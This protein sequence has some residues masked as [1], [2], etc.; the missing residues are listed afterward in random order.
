MA[1]SGPDGGAGKPDAG[2]TAQ[3]DSTSDCRLVDDRCCA[4][5]PPGLD[6]P[7]RAVSIHAREVE[8]PCEASC[9]ACPENDSTPVSLLADC[10]Q[11][12]CEV[13][14]LAGQPYTA[15][16]SDADCVLRPADCCGFCGVAG[17][18]NS[19]AVNGDPSFE[20]CGLSGLCNPV[21]CPP[22]VATV[23][24][25]CTTEGS[26]ST[27]PLPRDCAGLGC[28]VCGAE[29]V[30]FRLCVSGA[31]LGDS[32]CKP[33]DSRCE[34]G[35]GTFTDDFVLD[36]CVRGECLYAHVSG[37]CADF[38][39]CDAC[40]EI[41]FGQSCGAMPLAACAACCIARGAGLSGLG[42]CACAPFAPC[43]AECSGTSACGG[44]NAPSEACARCLREG[45][46]GGACVDEPTFQQECIQ[47]E[48]R[49]AT[50][51]QCLASCPD[52]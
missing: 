24:P 16:A 23:E 8:A 33:L 12:R 30:P 5:A 29:Q 1:R 9:D 22:L 4:C 47:G 6:D 34:M 52:E 31:C 42:A 49:C 38:T 25:F 17:L 10:M 35:M 19:Y 44:G 26:C 13:V 36:G 27:R 21:S 51:A 40:F 15:C 11:G 7:V 3:C 46:R 37:G 41:A 48:L 39:S 45:L 18:S 2:S 28:G 20:P 43:E 50:T 14:P 32:D